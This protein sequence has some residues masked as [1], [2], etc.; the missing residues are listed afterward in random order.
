M[1]DFAK[2][3]A[4]LAAAAMLALVVFITQPKLA[5]TSD[6]F[7]DTGSAFYPEF[8][9]A[10]KPTSLEILEFN[11]ETASVSPFKVQ[12]KDNRWTIPS[13]YD[14]PADA[15]DRLF[16]ASGSLIG[17]K[18]D[19]IVSD[20]KS[21]HVALGV[22]DPLEKGATSTK[23]WGTRVT[24]R[25]KDNVVCD[26]IIGKTVEGKSGF[27]YVRVPGKDRVYAVKCDKVDLSV[28]FAD[29]ID[30]DLL[31]LGTIDM[32]AV[33]IKEYRVQ[34]GDW[35]DRDK[36]F[37][38]TKDKDNNWV[39]DGLKPTEETDKDKANSLTSGIADVKIVGVRPKP[40]GLTPNLRMIEGQLQAQE[41]I[42][43]GFYPTKS[44]EVVSNDGEAVIETRDGIVYTLRFGGIIAGKGDEVTAGTKD[45]KAIAPEKEKKDEKD[46]KKDEKAGKE[47]KAEEKKL[48]VQENRFLL[49]TVSFD[50]T[51]FPEIPDPPAE[52]KEAKPADAK[53]AK[54]AEPA[55]DSKE[56]KPAAKEEAKKDEKAEKEAKE[57]E[58]KDKEDEAKRKKEEVEAKRKDR[59]RKIKEGEEKAK[60]LS[61]RYA[62]WYYVIP[63][64]TFKNIRLTRTDLAKAK[65]EEKP[66][67]GK[68]DAVNVP[69][70]PPPAP[71]KAEPKAEPKS[72]PKA[73]VKAE[74]KSE[75]KVEAK[76]EPKANAKPEPKTD[77]KPA[78]KEAPKAESKPSAPAE[79]KPKAEPKV[80]AKPK[81]EVKAEA[82]PKVE[83]KVE[84]KPAEKPAAKTKA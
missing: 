2:T 76:P 67:D 59:D 68:S 58:A 3:V 80:E 11:S 50:K 16:K 63:N 43:R 75:P 13:H 20:K 4:F 71:P 54:P 74:P 25:D 17:L 30:T 12:F 49:V 46:A 40:P 14:Y 81:A 62:K 82:K 7:D 22:I 37:V 1:S 33:T 78:A 69:I 72:Q 26:L 9:D 36:K 84:A 27:R 57:K 28:K 61:D 51:K 42:S 65:K 21:D 83:T 6:I 66:A 18:K 60:A 41:M 29:W 64:T 10:G 31:E 35:L 39:L 70:P 45:E 53:D 38:L 8:L 34:D 79:A 52:A 48:D 5:T 77:A 44:G 23:G 24:L 32:D 15:K 47:E 73:E 55:K 19:S 56:A